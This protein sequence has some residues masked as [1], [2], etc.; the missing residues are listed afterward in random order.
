MI[1]TPSPI[2][3]TTS[4]STKTGCNSQVLLRS[5]FH[6][7]LSAS[8]AI[9]M[10]VKRKVAQTN[11]RLMQ[12]AAAEQRGS[13]ERGVMQVIISSSSSDVD[14][15]RRKMSHHHHHDESSSSRDTV[16]VPKI[17]PT[18]TTKVATEDAVT[19]APSLKK[20][21]S[22]SNQPSV[23]ELKDNLTDAERINA[24]YQTEDYTE[25]LTRAHHDAHVLKQAS[26]RA[27]SAEYLF[28][29]IQRNPDLSPRG[30]E[31]IMHLVGNDNDD[32]DSSSDDDD[33]NNR[34]NNGGGCG[35]PTNSHYK[36]VRYLKWRHRQEILAMA[37]QLKQEGSPITAEDIRKFSEES[38]QWAVQKALKLGHIDAHGLI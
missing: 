11:A 28:H 27:P 23:L 38:S 34:R 19:D 33:D 21:V 37:H 1:S 20:S 25:F 10:C 24:W 36:R 17:A 2:T 4:T 6:H 35:F 8:T 15:K 13:E 31:K 5:P 9:S 22:F 12:S 3:A 26:M 16:S 32:D 7:Q 18:E 14:A 30:L 29:F